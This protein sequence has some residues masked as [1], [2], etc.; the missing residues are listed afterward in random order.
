M[1]ETEFRTRPSHVLEDPSAKAV[2]RVYA[3]SFLDA[4]KAASEGSP[5]EE[6]TSFHDDVLKANPQLETL[7]TSQV[8]RKEDKIGILERVVAPNASPFF[9]N[10]LRVLARH[11]RLDLM[12]LV[13]AE[14]WLEFEKRANQKR[15]QLKSA[16]PLSEE[17]LGRIKD[18]LKSTMAFDPILIT[19]VDTDMLGGLV[20]H[21]GDTVYDGSLRTKLRNLRGSL[22]ERYLHEIQSG[23]DR[24]RNS[25]GN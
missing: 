11:D 13:L 3:V 12:S 9:A 23:R 18:R 1:A 17:Q 5:L 16:V 24:F 14:A 15:V 22:R 7:L 25:E 6:F 20:I 21:I 2:A 4:A 19:E 10:F 8:T